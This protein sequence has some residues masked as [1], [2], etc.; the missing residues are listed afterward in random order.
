MMDK[1]VVRVYDFSPSMYIKD[2]DQLDDYIPRCNTLV[3]RK[4]GYDKDERPLYNLL[5]GDGVR[6]ID[7]M[8]YV[9]PVGTKAAKGVDEVE[10][11]MCVYC[12]KN[13]SDEDGEVIGG[14]CC[15]DCCW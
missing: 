15:G 9:V 8:G 3:L 7:V 11:P 5:V 1:S 6:T 4:I 13:R 2:G 10:D 12:D 14:G